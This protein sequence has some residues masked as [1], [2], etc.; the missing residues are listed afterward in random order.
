MRGQESEN[1]HFVF[2]C[3]CLNQKPSGKVVWQLS[4]VAATLEMNV[5][6]T[7]D[8]AQSRL[9]CGCTCSDIVSLYRTCTFRRCCGALILEEN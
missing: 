7:G 6:R 8:R 9:E 2:V 3:H 4:P 1:K 5:C